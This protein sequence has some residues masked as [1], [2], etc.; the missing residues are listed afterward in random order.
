MLARSPRP[1]LRAGGA[2][3]YGRA[4]L[5]AGHRADGLA[6]LDQAWDEYH[7]MGAWALRAAVQ[8]TMRE[9]GARRAVWSTIRTA[10]A[11]GWS[12][13]TKAE[14]R[15]AGLIAAGHTNKSAASVLG[16]SVNTV[17]AHLRAIFTKLGV[18]SRVQLTN[19]WHQE[20]AS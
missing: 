11:V 5:A 7:R 9:A 2:E 8:Q 4:L 6:Q 18:Q 14:R 16:V 13:L 19:R 15:V 3:S 12:S 20:Q 17:G 1:V 10:P